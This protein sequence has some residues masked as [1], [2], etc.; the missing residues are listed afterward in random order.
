MSLVHLTTFPAEAI[1]GNLAWACSAH[2]LFP[3]CSPLTGIQSALWD[4]DP[5]ITCAIP[6]LCPAG[7][8]ICVSS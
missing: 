5:L 2:S 4:L 8:L 1:P 3:V 7:P 6:E